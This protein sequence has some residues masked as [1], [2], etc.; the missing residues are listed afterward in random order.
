M[1]Q[2]QSITI[3]NVKDMRKVLLIMTL[4]L[5]MVAQGAWA[6][7]TIDCTPSDKNKVLCTDG[8][9]YNNVSA[10]EADSKTPV[11]KIIVVDTEN[12]KGLALALSD[13]GQMDYN[14]AKT[15]CNN[16]N[17]STPVTNAT[18]AI[19]SK[20][21]WD[22]MISAAGGRTALRD[23]FSGI[24][25]TN[26]S[27]AN[28]EV[29]WS[30]TKNTGAPNLVNWTYRFG[31]INSGWTSSD[32]GGTE[33]HVRLC[34]QFNLPIPTHNAALATGTPTGW[35]IT[36]TTPEEGSTVTVAY[37]GQ[38]RV[39]S[40]R[41]RGIAKLTCDNT[42]VSFSGSE[43]VNS[44]KTKVNV[45]AFGGTNINVVSSDE[46]KCTV[47]Y[48]EGTIT[49]TRQ[50]ISAFDDVQ[51]TVSVTPSDNFVWK[52]AN[53]VTFNVSGVAAAPSVPDGAISGKFSVSAT[54]Q[55]YF[56]KGNLRY[57]SGTW[58]FF[59]NQYDYYTS[60]SADAWD[61]F[62]WSTSATTYGMNTSESGNTYS[63]D[64]VDWGSNSDLQTALG[65]GWF[66]LSKDEWLYLFGM[67]VNN[68]DK[69]GHARYRKYFRAQVNGVSGIVVLPD[70]ISGIS[71]IPLESSRG[72]AS[73]FNGKTY[74]TVAWS[75]M[76][77][78]G[79][80]FLPAAGSRNGT[81]MYVSTAAGYCWSSS[82][83]ASYPTEAYNVD[84]SSNFVRPATNLNRM[85]GLSVRLV[86]DVE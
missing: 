44:T 15:A 40:V 23:G 67:E 21:E 33:V 39:K 79:C 80:V 14:A 38:H 45:S 17:T 41:V 83:S 65:T 81:K 68:T 57:A 32:Q 20:D 51:I 3:M 70:D 76:E 59:D 58:S 7:G 62:G 9:I 26:I 69:S 56:S 54:K 52:T 16:K 73:A 1:T 10:A 6:D 64:F 77:S 85:N 49:I 19:P 5:T 35:S 50:T 29:Y 36:P 8:S 48:S 63:G 24:G 4:L 71:D 31:D 37:T 55:V 86:R 75:A 13:E 61:K 18:W 11:A 74:T 66:T 60:Y 84:F 25:G 78:A 72:T 12:H 47:S 82:P 2:K 27:N 53:N 43:G 42:D 46:S 34:L 30:R 28:Q 22:Q